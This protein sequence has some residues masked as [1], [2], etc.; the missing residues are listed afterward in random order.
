M[1]CTP[2]VLAKYR[3]LDNALKVIGH[4]EPLYFDEETHVSPELQPLTSRQRHQFFKD[5]RLSMPVK[6][7]RYNP[8]GS[9][10]GTSVL[11]KTDPQDTTDEELTRYTRIIA[12]IQKEVPVFHSR[13]MR[14]AFKKR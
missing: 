1:P 13:S 7:F 2:I 10:I 14:S 9:Y 11:W 3:Y 12:K 5:L 4:Y 6:L 8:G